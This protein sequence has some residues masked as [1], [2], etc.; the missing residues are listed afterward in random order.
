MS[1]DIVVFGSGKEEI[2]TPYPIDNRLAAEHDLATTIQA[3]NDGICSTWIEGARIEE[4]KEV[5]Q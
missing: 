5:R 4:H 1:Y 2:M 3:I